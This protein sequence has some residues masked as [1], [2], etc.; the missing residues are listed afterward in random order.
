MKRFW[1][2]VDV[3]A[4]RGRALDGRP[5]RT[6]GRAPLALPTD[7]LAEAVADEWR[8]V[9]E[10][11]DPRAMPLTG[12]ANAAIDRIAPDPAQLRRRP[13]RLWRERPALLPRRGA[14]RRWSRGRRRHGTRCSTGRARATTCISRRPPASMHRAQP[15]ATL[16]RLARRWRRCDPFRARRPVAGGDDHRLAGAR[17]GA[18]RAARRRPTR[19]WAAAHVDEDWQAETVGRGSRLRS[20]GAR[21]RHKRARLRRRGRASSGAVAD[22]ALRRA[23]GSACG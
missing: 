12:L 14:R 1:T 21:C 7:A 10:T 18:G 2:E 6:P 13:G 15:A 9:G 8:A 20:T 5:V 4:D 19:L 11:I 16:A 22:R 17:A 23:S 3:D